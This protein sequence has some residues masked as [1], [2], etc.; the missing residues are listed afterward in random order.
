MAKA[1]VPDGIF[2]LQDSRKASFLTEYFDAVVL[3][4]SIV[5]LDGDEAKVVLTNAVKWLRMVAIFI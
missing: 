2:H 3:S 5:H 1:N 4:F